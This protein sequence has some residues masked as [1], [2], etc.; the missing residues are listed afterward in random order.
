MRIMFIREGSGVYSFGKRKVN[1]RIEK[2]KLIVRSGGGF[3]PIK[4]FIDLNTP[5]ELDKVNRLD[6]AISHFH[7]WF[8][9]QPDMQPKKDNSDIFEQLSQMKQTPVK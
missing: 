7:E 2:G 5:P 3:T 1:I 6:D 8:K 9:E 4:A